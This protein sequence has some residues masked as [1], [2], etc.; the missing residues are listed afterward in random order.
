M[1]EIQTLTVSVLLK[2]GFAIQKLLLN[3]G[4]TLRHEFTQLPALL[5][6][7]GSQ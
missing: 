4:L 5:W 3:T 7:D 1:G 2:A 6:A